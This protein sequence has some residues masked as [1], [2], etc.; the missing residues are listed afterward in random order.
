MILRIAE[1]AHASFSMRKTIL[2]GEEF[3]IKDSKVAGIFSIH[4]IIFSYKSFPDVFSLNISITPI[5]LQGF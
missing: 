4:W 3:P 2:K 5:I 1:S